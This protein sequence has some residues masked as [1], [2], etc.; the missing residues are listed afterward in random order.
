MTSNN[1]ATESLLEQGEESING[2]KA[3]GSVNTSRK[4]FILF[5]L[6]AVVGAAAT[7]SICSTYGCSPKIAV[8]PKVNCPKSFCYGHGNVTGYMKNGDTSHCKCGTCL[9]GFTGTQC[10]T[11]EV[12]GLNYL[13]NGFDVSYGNAYDITSSAG[14]VKSPVAIPENCKYVEPLN[15]MEANL[16]MKSEA[17]A[18]STVNTIGNSWAGSLGISYLSGMFG[19]S[20]GFSNIVS[21]AR[22]QE[23]KNYYVAANAVYKMFVAKIKDNLPECQNQVSAA[24]MEELKRL[25]GQYTSE[26]QKAYFDIFKDFGTHYVSTVTSGGSVMMESFMSSKNI[27]NTDSTQS[28]FNL[29]LELL[30]E[31]HV[32]KGPD[33]D[34]KTNHGHNSSS[35]Q[36]AEYLVSNSQNKLIVRGGDITLIPFPTPGSGMKVLPSWD[37]WLKTLNDIDKV[38]PVAFTLGN[39]VELPGIPRSLY[40]NLKRAYNDYLQVCPHSGPDDRVCSDQGVCNFDAAPK[41]KCECFYGWKGENCD[42]QTCYHDAEGHECSGHGTCTPASGD[43]CK[44]I[45]AWRNTDKA[46]CAFDCSNKLF[47][48]PNTKK[49]VANELMYGETY[50]SGCP[51]SYVKDGG[52]CPEAM[53]Y[54]TAT[55]WCQA[56]GFEDYDDS[57]SNLPVR[58]P[59]NKLIPNYCSDNPQDHYPCMMNSRCDAGIGTGHANPCARSVAA[60]K[61][62]KS[63]C[64]PNDST[65]GPCSCD[66]NWGGLANCLILT[67]VTCTNSK[68]KWCQKEV[69]EKVDLPTL[70]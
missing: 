6:V 53:Q 30:W 3:E 67:S 49:T 19:A 14:K 61:P 34:L 37:G 26:S 20:I 52:S 42:I 57:P 51:E 17:T 11:K 54:L 21:T 31:G 2:N 36:R 69:E 68:N 60:D 22:N 48:S 38:I 62:V 58:L 59:S 1:T 25:P 18:Y 56:Q 29:A 64:S 66:T 13:H 44:C 65:G 43:T 24:L 15:V 63:E 55:W 7:V 10:Q 39:L 46:A 16:N 33:V 32:K 27:Q 23:T 35:Q 8:T 5:I 50:V 28:D 41:A 47:E 70:D 12:P 9:F 45:G 4:Y 40:S